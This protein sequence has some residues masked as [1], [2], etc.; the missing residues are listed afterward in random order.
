MKTNEQLKRIRIQH[1]YSQESVAKA[2]GVDA[3]TISK[4]ESGEREVPRNN[5][6]Q[7]AALYGVSTE[8]LMNASDEASVR[9]TLKKPYMAPRKPIN[10][11]LIA[12][13]FLPMLLYLFLDLGLLLA[14]GTAGL[15]V[16][17]LW[18]GYWFFI[19]E[20]KQRTTFK[21]EK[22][23][24]VVYVHQASDADVKPLKRQGIINLLF[25]FLA[26]LIVFSFINVAHD[27]DL[28]SFNQMVINLVLVFNFLL[29]FHTFFALMTGN[30]FV[31]VI[32]DSDANIRLNTFKF[33]MLKVLSVISYTLL[34][35]WLG[36]IVHEGLAEA[37]SDVIM[38][39]LIIHFYLYFLYAFA[40]RVIEYYRFFSVTLKKREQ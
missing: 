32:E 24:R 23:K 16:N 29:I 30:I 5:L 11:V 20:P 39:A 37:T 2:I 36:N 27:A 9:Y 1:G 14:L 19:E 40:H 38:I 21:V 13:L 26:F 8:L 33:T 12:A 25:S 28:G 10:L 18:H 3:S 17:L 34:M 22:D 35:G 7:L 6:K 31:G 15:A 4:Y